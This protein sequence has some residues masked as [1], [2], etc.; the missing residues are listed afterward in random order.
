[1]KRDRIV[2]PPATFVPEHHEPCSSD[3][4]GHREDAETIAQRLQ[5]DEVSAEQRPALTQL[6]EL[7]EIRELLK[8]RQSLYQE[9]ADHRIDTACKTIEQVTQQIIEH[10]QDERTR[11]G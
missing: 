9:T 10:L 11:E 8:A 3:G 2:E 4:L 5:Q 6:D 7:E 1:M